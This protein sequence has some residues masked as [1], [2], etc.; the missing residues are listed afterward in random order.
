MTPREEDAEAYWEQVAEDRA[1][2]R[3]HRPVD[4]GTAD[5]RQ[6]QAEA[7]MGWGSL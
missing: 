6:D 5:R 1:W 7:E 4:K 3:A 2:D